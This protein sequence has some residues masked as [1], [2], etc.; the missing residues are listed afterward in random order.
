MTIPSPKSRRFLALTVIVTLT[1]ITAIGFV[2]Y[3]TKTH[4]P[5]END[6]HKDGVIYTCS[7]HPFIASKEP[8]NCPICGMTL[9]PKTKDAPVEQSGE[10]KIAYWKA[11]MNPREIYGKPGKSA[12]GMDLVPVY[13]DELKG[14]VDIRVDPVTRQSMGI[15]VESAVK[16]PLVHTIRAYGHVTYDETRTVQ[17]SPRFG[18]WVEK[19]YANV[20]GQPVTKGQAL[21]SVYSPELISAQEEYLGAYRSHRNH[22]G[23]KSTQSMLS[24]IRQRLLNYSISPSEIDAIEKLNAPKTSL[25]LASPISGIIVSKPI[26]EGGYFS[27][28][29]RVYTIS[30]LS[31]IWV[32]AHIYEYELALVKK[33]LNAE[34]T[35]PYRPGVVYRGK[36]AYI[37]PYLQEKTRD[38]VVRLEF[39]NADRTL[40]P[41]MFTDV[42]IRA[43]VGE[44]GTIIPREAVLRSG[45][46]N[47][48]FVDKGHG[49]FSPRNVVTGLTLDNDT[50]HV[51]S[52]IVPG[53]RVVVSG[54]FLLDSESKLKEALR[55]MDAPA[56]EPEE[57]ANDQKQDTAD[58]FFND[59]E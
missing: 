34:I 48:V 3:S 51:I 47:L 15:R 20:T 11:P 17:I 59:M 22:P 38:V 54:Q 33:G 2:V 30:D 4:R 35:L 42:M 19:L 14:G 41:D 25:I 32:E 5:M 36:V 46:Q 40:K 29:N 43:Q 9:V 1:A 58:D 13:E 27:A 52:G 57:P 7:M 16:G 6:T 28:G 24:A 37:Y 50:V 23:E 45:E 12:M 56:K 26:V 49:E 55:K 21:F 8:G 18:G 39:D 53:D 44:T 31:K 10:R